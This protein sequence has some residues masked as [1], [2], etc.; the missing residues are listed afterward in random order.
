MKDPS[1]DDVYDVVICGTDLIQSI[2]SSAL[3][4]AGK[5]VLHCDGNEWYGGF[6]AVLQNGSSLD[7]FI[8]GC[9]QVISQLHYDI[10]SRES[11]CDVS[12]KLKDNGFRMLEL[13]PREKYADLRLHSHTFISHATTQV[14]KESIDSVTSKLPA[15]P[16]IDDP[17]KSSSAILENNSSNANKSD[18]AENKCDTPEPCMLQHGFSCDIS[19]SLI[20][21]SGDAVYGLVK[22][23]VADYLEFKSLKG[24]YLLMAEGDSMKQKNWS[25]RNKPYSGKVGAKEISKDQ[26][27]TIQTLDHSL[28]RYRVPCSKGDVFRSKLLSPVEKRRLMK[29]L[30]LI[31]DYGATN[32]SVP[33]NEADSTDAG[34]A[35]P[36][37]S[38]A[39]GV[40]NES[41]PPE[42][43][44][45]VAT[46]TKSMA[47]DAMYS[48]NERHLNRG[49]ALSRPQNKAKPSSTE[50]DS[51]IRCI[52]DDVDFSDFL[53][54]VVK[55]PPRLCSVVTHAMA[56]APFG[57]SNHSDPSQIELHHRYLTKCGVGDLL[58][59]VSALGRFGDTAFLVPMYGSGELSQ[60]FCRSGAVYGSTYMLRRAPISVSVKL[61]EHGVHDSVVRAVILSGEEHIGAACDVDTEDTAKKEVMCN[62]VIVPNTMVPRHL[63]NS[64]L[65]VRIYRRISIL[66][67][68]IITQGDI[69]DCSDDGEQRYAIVIPPGTNGLDNKSAIHGVALDD[70]AFVAPAGKGFTVLHLTTSVL[71]DGKD[72]DSACLDI[73][74]KS[75]QFLIASQSSDDDSATEKSTQECHHLAFSYATDLPLP[76]TDI[77][78][79]SPASGLHICHRDIQSITCDY[80]FREA[81]RIFE[82]ICPDADFLALAKNVA[83]SI[84]YRN[85]D[86]SDD[87]KL[88]LSSALDIVRNIV[89]DENKIDEIDKSNRAN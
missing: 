5:K 83:D 32:E 65:R 33:L 4:R 41:P 3:S 69:K 12:D 9:Q 35:T 14:R 48:I 76:F 13:L 30:Q 71:D 43:N 77:E 31:S 61:N 86:D 39:H 70:S 24:L 26:E 68:K 23:G 20:Y 42:E 57:N 38:D 58:R 73:L 63:M 62:H 53:A 55:L 47:D 66:Q 37:T 54:D 2:L 87:E 17:T 64:S 49:R 46:S 34:D 56:L 45:A 18:G 67:G 82:S 72:C 16:E 8:E 27:S 10:D 50:M 22:S 11:A 88:V 6:D 1:P 15:K 81:K 89:D 28:I 51:L 7:S 29:F 52:R 79:K 19:P 25:E 78:L 75:V 84:I 60:A 44:S 80:A 36:R 74:G 21:A 59:H 40:Q 85:N